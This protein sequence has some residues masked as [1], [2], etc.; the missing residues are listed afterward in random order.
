MQNEHS[1]FVVDQ[2]SC[3]MRSAC[4]T[5]GQL[6]TTLFFSDSYCLHNLKRGFV[7]TFYNSCKFLESCKGGVGEQNYCNPVFYDKTML[8]LQGNELLDIAMA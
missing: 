4:L 5:F 1:T 3:A 2:K 7:I 8:S 6:Y